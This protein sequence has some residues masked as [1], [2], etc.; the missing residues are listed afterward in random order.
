VVN[1]PEEKLRGSITFELNIW[2]IILKKRF[3][4][5]N[6]I[7]ITSRNININ[8]PQMIVIKTN[9]KIVRFYDAF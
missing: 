8:N 1:L 3:S 5:T 9:R 4:N 6:I 7:S 2:S